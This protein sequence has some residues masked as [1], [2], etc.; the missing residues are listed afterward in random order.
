MRAKF[1]GR[2][3][4]FTWCAALVSA[5]MAVACASG[6]EG[7]ARKDIGNAQSA[8]RQAQTSNAQQFAPLELKLAQDKLAQAHEALKQKDYKKARYRAREAIAD[9]NLAAS[10]SQNAKTQEAVQALES[11]IRQLRK[12]ID[13]NSKAP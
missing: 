5:I 2:K 11:S 9:A 12:Q 8:L 6:N 7:V 1:G 4:N 3:G 10:K 13:Q